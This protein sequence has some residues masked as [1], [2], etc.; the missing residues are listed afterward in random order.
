MDRC[1]ICWE[2]MSIK[3]SYRIEVC[4]HTF[5]GYCLLKWFCFKDPKGPHP[6]TCTQRTLEAS[7]PMCRTV[8]TLRTRHLRRCRSSISS[9]KPKQKK[10]FH[11]HLMRFFCC[12]QSVVHNNGT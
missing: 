2:N 9:D 5:H 12:T 10:C 6:L 4:K 3:N 8:L 7:C 1:P 11:K